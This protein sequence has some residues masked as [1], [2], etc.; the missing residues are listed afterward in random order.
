MTTLMKPPLRAG[1]TLLAALLALAAAGASA[2]AAPDG[3]WS[4]SVTPYLWGLGLSGTVR[5]LANGPTLTVDRSLGD[6]LDNLDAAGFVT[7]LARRDDWVLVGDLTYSRSS[8]EGRIGPPNLPPALRPEAKARERQLTLSA[9]VGRTISEGQDSRVDLLAGIRAWRLRAEI[10]VPATRIDVRS[11]TT[12]TD[13]IVGVR[14]EGPIGQR[15][16]AMAYGDVGGF[17]IDSK[18]TW[19]VVAAAKRSVGQS[20]HLSLGWRYLA[21]DYREDGRRLDLAFAGP[22]VGWT[23]NFD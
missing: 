13:P 12:I 18:L 3:R 20:S 10:S 7:G 1:S 14:W 17:G 4:G 16:S 8:M 21:V 6:L 23:W 19:Q 15:W 2:Q 5:P 9:M 22:V 11:T